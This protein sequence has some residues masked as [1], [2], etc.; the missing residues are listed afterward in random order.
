MINYERHGLTNHPIYRIW[1]NMRYRTT[2]KTGGR[3]KDWGG[4]GITICEKWMESASVFYQWAISNG[5]KKGLM[6]DRIDND[7]NYEPSNCRFV[8]CAESAHNRRLLKSTNTSGY[9][10]IYLDKRDNRWSAVIIVNGEKRFLGCFDSPMLAAL[11]WDVEAYILNDNR[12]RN[13]F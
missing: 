13:L 3:Y 2:K 1:I 5:W 12:P 8:T 4:R 9:C 7:G 11:R 6:I 10:G